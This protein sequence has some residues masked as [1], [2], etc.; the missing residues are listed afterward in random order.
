MTISSSACHWHIEHKL[1]LG[2]KRNPF[3]N[4]VNFEAFQANC[5]L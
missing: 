4:E 2:T 5:L 1:F 3:T